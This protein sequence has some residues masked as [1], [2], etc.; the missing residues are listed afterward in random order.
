[1]LL[2]A[3]MESLI[4]LLCKPWPEVPKVYALA[5]DRMIPVDELSSYRIRGQTYYA[6][7]EQGEAVPCE[8]NQPSPDHAVDHVC[9]WDRVRGLCASGHD[10]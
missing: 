7:G 3:G 6:W 10:V 8:F 1:M 2:V 5:H 4:S 9:L